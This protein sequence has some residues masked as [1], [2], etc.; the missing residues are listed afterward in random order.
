MEAT[1]YRKDFNAH[2]PS[3][4]DKSV[5][6]EEG[7]ICTDAWRRI[8]GR[9]YCANGPREVTCLDTVRLTSPS[10]IFRHIRRQNH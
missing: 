5:G 4:D 8:M 6:A 7:L 1:R 10:A 9:L 2:V 3:E